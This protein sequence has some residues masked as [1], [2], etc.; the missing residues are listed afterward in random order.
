MQLNNVLDRLTVIEAENK[1]I[2]NQVSD[3]VKLL[4]SGEE[5][6]VLLEDKKSLTSTPQ[7]TTTGKGNCSADIQSEDWRQDYKTIKDSLA[8][9]HLPNDS[10]LHE[11]KYGIPSKEREHA[12][13]LTKC[14]RP[15]ETTPKLLGK[16]QNNYKD[17]IH[18]AQC[19]D[20][21][22]ICQA[23]LVRYIQEEYSSI[24]TG[25][26]YSHQAKSMFKV[27]H[28]NSAVFPPVV[29][30]SMK[31]ALALTSHH[32][33]V[34]QSQQ[35]FQ[36]RGQFYPRGRGQHFSFS[37]GKHINNLSSIQHKVINADKYLL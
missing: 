1:H 31:T 22:Y 21:V 10:Q 11:M 2:I 4:E 30:E 13:I 8:K 28:R 12:A 15:T 36:P 6:K 27:V 35:C 34:N 33:Q 23:A 3:R 25:G 7:D 26:Q 29:L 9:A 32:Q 5:P 20:N 37:R 18:V 17:P 14:C 24:F 19:I 16:I